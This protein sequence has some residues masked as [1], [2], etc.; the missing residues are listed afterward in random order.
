LVLCGFADVSSMSR[1]GRGLELAPG[2]VPN[3]VRAALGTVATET[4]AVVR[5]DGDLGIRTDGDARERVFTLLDRAQ[6]E[7]ATKERVYNTLDG[8]LAQ[9]IAELT[10]LQLPAPLHS[11][12]VE[13]ITA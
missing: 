2:P 7:F 4:G 5:V 10:A 1:D 13:L 8:E 12:I 6:I 11:A 3:S 9:V